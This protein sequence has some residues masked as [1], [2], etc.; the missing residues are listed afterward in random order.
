M[1]I[2]RVTNAEKYLIKFNYIFF[3]DF[4]NTLYFCGEKLLAWCLEIYV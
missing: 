1:H 3:T 2:N 4:K